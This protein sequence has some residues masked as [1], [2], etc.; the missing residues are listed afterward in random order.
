VRGAV[1]LAAA[2]AISSAAAL[3]AQAAPTPPASAAQTPV[4]PLDA[5]EAELLARLNALRQ[6]RGVRPLRHS[7]A[8]AAAADS[9]SRSQADRGVVAHRV[10][11][12]PA[13]HRR[14]ERFYPSQGYRWWTVGENIAVS[15]PTLTARQAIRMWM[16]TPGHRRNLLSRRWRDVGF[17][18][19]HLAD[20]PGLLAGGP[21]II[22]TVDFG[23]RR[24]RR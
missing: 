20:G 13:F 23:A 24:K 14:I 17:G 11:G 6:R 4:T 19:V 5:L 18:A 22:V 2:V 21:T 8:L 3:G 15:G 10:S 1:L 9:H 12:E 16:A 7:D